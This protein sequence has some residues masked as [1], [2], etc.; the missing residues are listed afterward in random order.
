MNVTFILWREVPFRILQTSQDLQAGAVRQGF[1]YF[2]QIHAPYISR[3]SD[4]SIRQ[5]TAMSAASV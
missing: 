4:M 3:F 2:E 5:R 1:E